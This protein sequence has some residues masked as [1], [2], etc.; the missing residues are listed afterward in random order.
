MLRLAFKTYR[1]S[2]TALERI[3]TLCKAYPLR[4]TLEARRGLLNGL[5]EAI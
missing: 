5:A 2:K 1:G 4:H 3:Y